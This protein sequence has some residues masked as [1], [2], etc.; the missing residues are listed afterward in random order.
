MDEHLQ[1]VVGLDLRLQFRV[2]H[3]ARFWRIWRDLRQAEL[4]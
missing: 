1:T 3:W 2:G 4:P